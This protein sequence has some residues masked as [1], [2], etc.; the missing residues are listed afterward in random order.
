MLGPA[1]L[2]FGIVLLRSLS[3]AHGTGAIGPKDREW[4]VFDTTVQPPAR[5]KGRCATCH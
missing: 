3:L 2:C 4:V 1:F 5:S